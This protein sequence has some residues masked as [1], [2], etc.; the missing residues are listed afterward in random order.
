MRWGQASSWHW[1][2]NQMVFHTYQKKSMPKI[3]EQSIFVSFR[4]VKLNHVRCQHTIVGRICQ[5]D[6][7]DVN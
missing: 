7:G 3:H 2:T 4:S 6:W 5:K 1:Q